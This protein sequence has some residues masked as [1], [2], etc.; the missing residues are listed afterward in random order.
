MRRGG[1][2]SV[3]GVGVIVGDG[4]ERESVLRPDCLPSGEKLCQHPLKR[5][6]SQRKKP[7]C[8]D[9]S[10]REFF[11][12]DKSDRSPASSSHSISGVV[13]VVGRKLKRGLSF[14]STC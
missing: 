14:E 8:S 2:S 9:K 3:V 1:G 5:R 13:L 10:E 12:G 4:A 11:G 6:A 7:R